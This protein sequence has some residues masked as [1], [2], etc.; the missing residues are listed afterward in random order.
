MDKS[1]AERLKKR[2]D[3]LFEKRTPVLA[4]WQAIA[5]QF[6]FERADFTVVRNLG[7]EVGTDLN[8][9]YP[10]LVRRELGD[11]IAS[12]LRYDEWFDITTN[13]EEKL[14]YDAKAWLQM[15]T[16][17]QRRAMENIDAQFDRATKTGDHDFATFGQCVISTKLNRVERHLEYNCWHLR[18]CA[19]SQNS[20][21]KIDFF[22]RKWKM[23]AC[24]LMKLFPGKCSQD[25]KEKYAKDPYTEI[26]GYE[27]VCMTE[28]I[29]DE[30]AKRWKYVVAF[31]EHKDCHVIETVGSRRMIYSVPR[32]ATLSSQYAHSPATMI[33]LPDAR[34]LQAMTGTL[35]RAGAKAVDPPMAAR[36]EVIRSDIQG[37]P[38]GITWIDKSHDE[39]LGPALQALE[40]GK[41]GLPFGQEMS[42]Q[43]ML[44]LRE[45]FFL[46]KLSQPFPEREITAYEASKRVAE[47]IRQALP[48]FRPMEVDYNGA[49][50][51]ETFNA[52]LYADGPFGGAF[53]P[54]SEMPASLQ[55]QDVKFKFRTPLREAADQKKMFQLK[56]AKEMVVTVIDLDKTVANILDTQAAVRDALEGN[57][58]PQTWMRSEEDVAELTAKQVA[59][60]QAAVEMA[61]LE[62][63]ATIAKDLATANQN[64]AQVPQ[65]R[66][67]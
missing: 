9:S 2:A 15:A 57:V 46:N 45:Y 1:V 51:E 43:T 27:I 16:R 66:A 20:A 42:Q 32:W 33:A 62:Q 37:Y 5:E 53:G 10:A 38:G 52:L 49:L 40:V 25:V 4:L 6:Y 67:A 11:S 31:I 60:E 34:M 61:A 54:L 59:D 47:Y 28:Y 39:R 21:G 23:W 18:D 30:R 55:N 22:A 64:F 41:H 26:D 50:C 29:D 12:M 65:G 36:A 63:G 13:R 56:Q 24:E 35:L 44:L 19:W 48:L 17:V 14:D 3:V 58:T 7:S 8:T